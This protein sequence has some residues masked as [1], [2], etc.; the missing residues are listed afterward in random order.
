MGFSLTV[1]TQRAG[2]PFTAPGGT[3]NGLPH[4][5]QYRITTT[6]QSMCWT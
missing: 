2:W 5:A 3:V 4:G 6:S 1:R